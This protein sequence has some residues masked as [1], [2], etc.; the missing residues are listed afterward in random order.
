MRQEKQNKVMSVLLA[1]LTTMT[2]VVFLVGSGPSF[3]VEKN[4]FMVKDLNV[5]DKVTLESVNGTVELEYNG[6]FWTVNKVFR[7]DPTMLKVLFATLA[8]NEPKRPV[9]LFLKDS[10]SSSLE[11]NGV[12]VKLYSGGSELKEFFAGG[13][14]S[15]TKAYFK[16]PVSDEVY[17]MTIPGYRV[18]VSGI[19]ELNESGFRDKKV[20]VFNWRNFKS[21]T[22]TFPAK[23][24]DNF[25]VLLQKD[26]FTIEGMTRVDTARLNV[27]GDDLAMLSAEKYVSDKKL[28]DS[29]SMIVPLM[30]I[31]IYDIAQRVYVLKLFSAQNNKGILG[32]KDDEVIYFN[33]QQIR[34]IMRPKSFFTRQ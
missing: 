23:P 9:A 20:F 27:F 25:T 18:Y 12:R 14:Q 3:E 24:N 19:Y 26:F 33:P 28:V 29:L 4:I 2:L 1:A 30:E 13:N 11:K 7:A 17:V 34:S 10:I 16:D 15:K 6:S 32:L 21:L 8:Q 31:A 22:A 5:I